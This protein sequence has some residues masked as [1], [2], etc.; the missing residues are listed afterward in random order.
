MIAMILKMP[1][2]FMKEISPELYFKA[3]I[4]IQG[5]KRQLEKELKNPKISSEQRLIKENKVNRL[6]QLFCE[7]TN[8]NSDISFSDILLRAKNN[9]ELVFK[10][11]HSR[12]EEMLNG[13]YEQAR[14]DSVR[15]VLT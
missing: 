2:I 8:F 6:G 1:K 7:L 10:H 14:R 13:I 15:M 12:V 9:S 3:L 11:Y 4:E 5:C